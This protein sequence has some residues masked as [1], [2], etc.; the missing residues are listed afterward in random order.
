M[1]KSSMT[2]SKTQYKDYTQ[3][4]QELQDYMDNRKF[5]FTYLSDNIEKHAEPNNSSLYTKYRDLRAG[6][7]PFLKS[8]PLY[9]VSEEDKYL[10]NAM[11]RAKFITYDNNAKEYK[12]LIGFPKLFIHINDPEIKTL[13]EITHPEHYKFLEQLQLPKILRN[14]MHTINDIKV[15]DINDQSVTKE[16]FMQILGDIEPET[17]KTVMMFGKNRQTLFAAAKRQM[18]TAP[19][20]TEKC[21]KE[22]LKYA[23]DR[24]ENDIGAYLDQFSYNE[25]Q[26]YS[27]LSAP[28]QL[29]IA[30]I[31]MYYQNPS[32]F[33]LLYTEEEKQRILTEHYEAIVKSELQ[34]PDGKPRMVCAIPDKIKY[35]MGPICWQLEE[36]CAKHLRG[37]CG[38]MNLTEMADKINN[39]AMQGFTKVV[40]GDGSAFDNSQDISLKALDRYIY[41]RIQ[42]KVYHVP[43]EDFQHVSNLYYKT[44]DVK[45]HINGKPQTMMTYKVLGTVFSGD[46][47]TTLANTIR[48]AMYNIFVN[49]KE[50]LKYGEDF[51]VFSKGDDFSVLYKEYVS[52]T[53]IRS[54]Y[55][56][57]FLSKP[58]S[59]FKIYD[60]RKYGIGQIC[61]FLDIGDLSTFKFCSLRSW[62]VDENLDRITL[63][64]NPAKLFGIS[65]YAIKPKRYSIKQLIQYHID[66]AT[67]YE[68]SY[69]NITVFDTMA[70]AHKLEAAYLFNKY[71]DLPQMQKSIRNIFTRM[72]RKKQREQHYDFGFD[73]Y[74]NRQLEE[75][76]GIKN[77]E[78]FED[79]ILPYYW[80]NMQ[81]RYQIRTEINTKQEY[82]FI[83]QQINAEFDSEELK[84]LVGQINF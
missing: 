37:Y 13:S 3:L 19:N 18:K 83:N 27:H 54:I 1:V 17:E 40:E 38:G 71:K 67:A 56:T 30:P 11:E 75:L 68:A 70:A 60:N 36:I 35:N 45:Y 8:I 79:L 14:N 5:E 6:C 34:D 22:F 53:F 7:H 33:N 28:K 72:A 4:S 31:R 47:D 46:S 84:S 77:R 41:N 59:T 26:W 66:Q 58:E 50:G 42:N 43:L 29:K 20:P 81:L 25:A 62:Y 76:I 32:E 64:R 73:E 52:D 51:V 82:E 74:Y 15:R 63:T 61:K 80:D 21:A 10:F 69:K 9:A 48:M 24:I 44:M 12:P 78:D 16:G 39:Y 49:E 57:Y 55:N 2:E 65:R 23:I